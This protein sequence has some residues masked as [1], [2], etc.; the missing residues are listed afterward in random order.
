MTSLHYRAALGAALLLATGSRAEGQEAVT[1]AIDRFLARHL[2]ETPNP[3]FSAVVVKGGQTIFAKGYGVEVAGTRRP[4][5]PRSPVA[6]GSQTKSLTAVAMM[7]LVERGK[8]DLDAPVVRYLPWFRTADRRGAEITIRMLLHNTSGIPSADRGLLSEDTDEGAIER[9]VRG[10]SRVPL[11]RA[12]GKSFEYSN[13]NWSVAGAVISAVSGLP[14]STFLEREVLQ[15]LGMTRSTTARDRLPAIG[16]LWGHY[17]EPDG[18]RPAAPRFLAVGLPAGSELRVSAE[19]MGRYLAM[20]LRKGMAG[21]RR[22]LTEESVR[23]LFAPGSVTTVN[24]PEMGVLAGKTG[25]AMGWAVI[26]F[27]GRTL[28]H[29]GGDAIVMGS[30][31]VIDTLANT[32]ASILYAGPTLDPYR[33]PSKFWVVHNLIRLANRQPLSDLGRP[34]EQD[35]TRNDF[36]LPADRFDRYAGTYLSA[37]GQRLTIEPGADG[38]RLLLAL[39]AGSM[40]YRYALDFASEGSAVLRNIGGAAV[41]QFLMT[42]AGQVTGLAG[43]VPGGIYR[44]RT[45]AELDR[46]Q[47]L[48]SPTGR[49]R[50]QLPRG[51]TVRWAGD[52]FEARDGSDS[53]AVVRGYLGEGSGAGRD[54]ASPEA[55]PARSETIGRYEWV[56]RTWSEGAAPAGRQRMTAATALGTVGFRLEASTRAGRLTALL[57]DVVVPLLTTLD[58]GKTRVPAEPDR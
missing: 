36:E 33:Y 53:T 8:V 35:P 11:V 1:V 49:L 14:Y 16:A 51:W 2:A 3:G 10:L 23:Q 31:T 22:F 25:Y 26:D 12:P 56:R 20:L 57:R 55:P 37:E 13:E 34:K 50:I 15:P 42:P 6:I 38:R 47:E 48:R 54:P 24:M 41:T 9:E 17:A 52:G 39:D 18:V 30:W 32:A 45:A 29:H 28:I 21:S 58:L 5:T 7:R 43:A 40:R 46:I 27:E 4:M 44:K 19:D